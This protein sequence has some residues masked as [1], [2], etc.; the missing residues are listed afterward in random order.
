[1][2]V[3]LQMWEKNLG[4]HAEFQQT[5]FA[6]FLKDLHK[7]RFQMF[8]IGW[9]ADY[10]DPENFLDLLFYSES[11]NNHTNYSNPEVDALLKQARTETDQVVRYQ[12]YNRVE[13]MII[14]DAPW[15]PLWYS[16]ERYVLVKPSVHDY[17]LT[18]LYI[19]RLRYVYLTDQ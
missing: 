9:I 19:P 10:P 5:E 8:D 14:D 12:L 13:Q 1:M 3:V 4:V 18:P 17:F 6:T 11:S 15:I 2:E 16:G 7:R